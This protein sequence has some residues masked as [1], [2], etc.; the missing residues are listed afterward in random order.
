[1]MDAAPSEH[2]DDVAAPAPGNLELVR[3]FLSLHD[4][5]LGTPGS[6]APSPETLDAWLRRHGGVGRDRTGGRDLAWGL[7]VLEAL[8][9]ALGTPTR[10][11]VRTLDEAVARAGLLPVFDETRGPIRSEA[12]GVAGA[13]GRVLAIA[14]LARL[15]GSWDRLRTCGNPSCRAVLFDHTKNRSARWCSMASCGNRNKVRSFRARERAAATGDG[16]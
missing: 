16:A 1:M 9:S 4:H 13:L 3:S 5:V 7:D 2:E 8:R 14:F 12:G 11:D 6:I 10:G 15:D